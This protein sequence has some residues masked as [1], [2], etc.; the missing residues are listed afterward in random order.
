M[1]ERFSLR[2]SKLSCAEGF[3][4]QLLRLGGTL[5]YERIRLCLR[6]T[7]IRLGPNYCYACLLVKPDL[8]LTI[9]VGAAT[10]AARTVRVEDMGSGFSNHAW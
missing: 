1:K 6:K 9:D 4:P 10:P 5:S 3:L 8:E 2:L 7:H